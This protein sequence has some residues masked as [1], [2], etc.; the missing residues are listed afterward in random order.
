MCIDDNG[1]ALG[2]G[3]SVLH[4][5]PIDVADMQREEDDLGVAVVADDL[6]AITQQQEVPVVGLW[7]D[8][9][10]GAIGKRPS[11]LML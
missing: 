4:G 3:H 5:K 6:N 7:L 10:E 9:G 1:P 11:L 2:D 8:G